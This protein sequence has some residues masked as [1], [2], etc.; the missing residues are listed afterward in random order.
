MTQTIGSLT[1]EHVDTVDAIYYVVFWLVLLS[2]CYAHWCRNGLR[3][4]VLQTLV[5]LKEGAATKVLCLLRQ[6]SFMLL[7]KEVGLFWKKLILS[8]RAGLKLPPVEFRQLVMMNT[9][10]LTGIKNHPINLLKGLLWAS[11]PENTETDYSKL[12]Y[13]YWPDTRLCE[14]IYTSFGDITTVTVSCAVVFNFFFL[15][16]SFFLSHHCI[17]KSSTAYSVVLVT[18]WKQNDSQIQPKN[19]YLE[20]I[21]L[22]KW[23]ESLT[24]ICCVISEQIWFSIF[25][26]YKMRSQFRVSLK[27]KTWTSVKS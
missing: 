7:L 9:R 25:C 19:V 20:R 13:I 17:M 23:F 10:L 12:L 18:A 11:K 26:T 14:I 21:C 24:E 3:P 6:Y 22:C 1:S 27:V 8:H 16:R 4:S 5:S 2:F 15:C